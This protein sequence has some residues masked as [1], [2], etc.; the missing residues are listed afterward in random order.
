M[1]QIRDVTVEFSF[2]ECRLVSSDYFICPQELIE[3]V[4]NYSLQDP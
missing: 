1:L 2:F 4:I 3:L